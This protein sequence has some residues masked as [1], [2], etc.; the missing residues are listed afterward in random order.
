MSWKKDLGFLA[1]TLFAIISYFVLALGF[2]VFQRYPVVHLLLA[3]VGFAGLLWSLV[4]EFNARRLVFLLLAGVFAGGYVWY[5]L[6]YSNYESTD[7]EVSEGTTLEALRGLELTAHDG[8]STPVLAS[9][10]EATATLMV[11]YRGFW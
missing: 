9:A 4:H 2:G 11:F 8:S 7:V 6:D 3:L 10:N 1:L 5:T